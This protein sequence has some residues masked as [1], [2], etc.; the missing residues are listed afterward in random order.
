MKRFI[1]ISAILSTGVLFITRDLYAQGTVTITTNDKKQVEEIKKAAEIQKVEQ[2]KV[3]EEVRKAGE[4]VRR[5][6]ESEGMRGNRYVFDFPGN[7]YY[8][9]GQNSFGF[10]MRGSG[11]S[12]DFA[13]SVS[14]NTSSKEY[15]F[16]VEK[17]MKSLSLSISG[18]CKTGEI[19]I[20]VMM[21]GNKSYSEVV[22]DEFG[23]L[24]W[25][26]SFELNEES[27]D[28]IGVWKFKVT[29]TKATGN[30]RLSLSAS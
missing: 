23:N 14:D 20:A 9:G 8:G 24:N 2:V 21:P 15:T 1:I 7:A 5:A 27:K 4:E 17:D 10:Q 12:W 28:K 16:E 22:I 30:F 18:M 13:R 11:T 6:M 25:R 26:K 29:T 3:Q 19:R